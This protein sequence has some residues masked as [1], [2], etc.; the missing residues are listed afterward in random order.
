MHKIIILSLLCLI[1]VISGCTTETP[2]DQVIKTINY[3]DSPLAEM[4]SN[5][6]SNAD[7]CDGVT[8]RD[9][10]MDCGSGV[11]ITCENHCE[12]GEC[13]KCMPTC[14]EI[15]LDLPGEE[16]LEEMEEVMEVEEETE[17]TDVDLCED[18]C[19]DTVKTCPDGVDTFCENTCDPDTGDC[20]SCTPDCS[21]HMLCE[22]AW[23]C[24]DWSDCENNEK[25]RECTDNND[26]GTEET[27]PDET[28]ECE[29][30]DE[31]DHIIFSEILYDTSITGDK[32]EWVEI[33]NP[34]SYDV[35]LTGWSITDNIKPW[36]FPDDTL[37]ETKSYLVITKTLEY[38]QNISG[39]DTAITGFLLGL[40]NDGDQLTLKDSDS[41]EID[42][43]AWESGNENTY[44]DWTISA[45]EDE[46]IRRIS[47][48]EDTDSPDDWISNQE[49]DPFCA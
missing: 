27:K 26:C 7:S 12:D 47:I 18:T 36:N 33:Y 8:C 20:S 35:D 11:R 42:F 38:F 10:V 13:T 40:N 24:T 48:N 3:E 30:I 6:N 32:G 49:A 9:T 46:S 19:D 1:V 17:E 16:D 31:T 28:L 15:S 4:E 22:E 23:E 14:S 45:D 41:N 25:A 43:M 21:D 29:V 44:P 5:T 2:E 39:C 34:T 37:I